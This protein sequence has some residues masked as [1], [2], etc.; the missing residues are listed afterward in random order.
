M[1]NL[2]TTFG[3][4]ALALALAVAAP[5]GA[6]APGNFDEF[7]LDDYRSVC[8][9]DTSIQCVDRLPSPNVGP[10]L[11]S[12]IECPGG[13]APDSCEP[14]LIPG[15]KLRGIL[16]LVAD[17]NSQDEVDAAQDDDNYTYTFFL[18]IL[19]G[20]ARFV[21][22]ESFYAGPDPGNG[23]CVGFGTC[24]AAL[25]WR[26][27]L[28]ES[29]A[30]NIADF[31]GYVPRATGKLGPLRTRL[32]AFALQELGVVGVPILR[33]RQP[34]SGGPS[35]DGRGDDQATVGRLRVEIDF[36][37]PLAPPP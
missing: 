18:D 14:D 27:I 28:D 5:T 12:G 7:F 4:A 37:Q 29:A 15:A 31:T 8:K 20:D 30:L 6:T 17:E 11:F 22:A 23:S 25:P 10:G 34:K 1:T 21:H 36:A 35:Q 3:A 24:V 26:P 32:D 2:P 33:A 13:P 9:A 19:H 16:T